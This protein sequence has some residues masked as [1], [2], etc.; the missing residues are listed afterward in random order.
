MIET[1]NIYCDESGHLEND[2]IPY[3]LLGYI[4]V[5]QNKLKL[6]K[7]DI[8]AIKD[9]HHFYSEIKW[10]NVSSSKAGFYLDLINFFFDSDLTFRVLVIKKEDIKNEI[11]GQDFDT[12]YYK[13]YYQLLHHQIDMLFSYNIYLDIKDTLSSWKVKKLKEILQT[14]YGVIK[15]LQNIRSHESPFLQLAD[16]IIGAIGYSLR[17]LNRVNAKNDIIALLRARSGNSLQRST[18]KNEEKL[19]MFFIDLS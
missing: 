15:N 13:M 11:Y 4:S 16:L 2:G 8:A 5:P 18:S 19:N 14:K 9:K 10:A 6:Y 17:G 3:M 7:R 12:F 1:F